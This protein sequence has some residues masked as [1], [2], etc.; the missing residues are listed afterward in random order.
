MF[1]QNRQ[2]MRQFYIDVWRKH[3]NKAVLSP[4]EAIV[5]DVIS[6]HPEYHHEL[7]DTDKALH[8]DYDSDKGQSNPFLHMGLHIGLREQVQADHP[9]GIKEL[10]MSFREKSQDLHQAEHRMIECMAQALWDAQ[11]KQ[12]LP[13]DARYLEC[14]RR[15]L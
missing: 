5:S 13:D 11:N 12:G 15:S 7:L 3:Q 10:Y 8:K 9:S 4:L 2:Q 6:M 14:L 1:N